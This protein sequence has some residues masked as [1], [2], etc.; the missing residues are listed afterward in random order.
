LLACIG[1]GL[2]SYSWRGTGTRLFVG[3]LA[4]PHQ[5]FELSYTRLKRGSSTEPIFTYGIRF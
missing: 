5:T 3:W 1:A 2:G 4:G